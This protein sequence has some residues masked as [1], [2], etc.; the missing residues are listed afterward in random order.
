MAKQQ[1]SPLF[2]NR[3]TASKF[4]L[5][6]S[7]DKAA[8][9][10]DHGG[11][12][13]R[14]GFFDTRGRAVLLGP[15][16]KRL[17]EGVRLDLP[18]YKR[19][20]KGYSDPH[21]LPEHTAGFLG[22]VLGPLLRKWGVNRLGYAK[23]GPVTEDGVQVVAPQIWGPSVTNVPYRKMLEDALGLPGRVLHGNDMWAAA[24]DII[25]R[26]ASRKPPLDSQNFVVITVSSGI[27]SKVVVNG[28]VQLGV[29]GLA[30]EIGHMPVLWPSDII[31]GRRCGCGELYCLEAGSSGDATAF[32][33][34][35]EADRLRPLMDASASGKLIE[36]ISAITLEPG[37]DLPARAKAINT[38]VVSA[39]RRD[40][41]LAVSILN[42]STRPLARAISA[43]ENQLNITNYYFVGGYA[44]ALGDRFLGTLREALL[45]YGIIGRTTEQIMQIGR[46]YKVGAQ[47]WGLRGAA[48]AALHRSDE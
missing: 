28:K 31:P 2:L 41:P 21:D 15:D 9:A 38:A 42:A 37:E 27:G 32:R 10:I 13:P 12:H 14:V 23:A 22:K 4:T 26:G 43:L 24:S 36:T 8:A 3:N 25:A 29:E 34:K 48:M 46:M 5:A 11:T 1:P 20:P 6:G 35:A 16:R 40:D 44:L 18:T 39:A 30:G 33:A 7:G 19:M 17:P 45:E 47:D